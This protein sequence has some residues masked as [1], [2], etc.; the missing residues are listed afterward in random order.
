[1]QPL[2]HHEIVELVAPFT[3]RGRHVDL[4]AS[5]RSLRRLVFRAVERPW[6]VAASSLR[7]S[8]ELANPD[9][10]HYRLTR[11][12]QCAN[13]LT[14]RLETAGSDPEELLGDIEQIPPERQFQHTPEITTA[15]SHRI[16]PRWPT[17]GTESR[18]GLPPGE[19]LI[20]AGAA[21]HAGDL[22]LQLDEPT[23]LGVRAAVHVQSQSSETLD[24]PEDL[25]A[26]LGSEWAPLKR[27][28]EGQW[29]GSL[30]LRSREPARSRRAE[31]CWASGLRHLAATLAEPPRR[32]HERFA[33]ARW[34]VV[35]RRALPLIGCVAL[36]AGAASVPRLHLAETSG[37]RMLIFNAPPILMMLFFCLRELP[38]IEIPPVPS[39]SRAGRWPLR[40]PIG[41]P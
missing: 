29:R 15:F 4:A 11:V 40:R 6:V 37:L 8:L 41:T 9:P 2:T 24:L 23:R 33:A 39:A 13:G 21:A 12:L 27:E 28:H 32:F 34:V 14:A 22:H 1:M 31:I 17:D 5:D 7:E 18:A 20:L 10:E 3:R 38:H 35:L 25:L 26:V 16:A 36:I 30:R 19:R